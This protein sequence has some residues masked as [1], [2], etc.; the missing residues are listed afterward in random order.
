[1][2]NFCERSEHEA[3][4]LK[5]D[6]TLLGVLNEVKACRAWQNYEVILSSEFGGGGHA[7]SFYK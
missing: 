2:Q 1:L 7:R 5:L 4:A 6:I 3:G